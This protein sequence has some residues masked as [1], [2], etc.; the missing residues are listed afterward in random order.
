MLKGFTRWSLLLAVALLPAVAAAQPTMFEEEEEPEHI[1]GPWLTK[2]MQERLM[3]KMADDVSRRYDFDED[4]RFLTR[5]LFRE[6]IPTWLTENR[7]KIQPLVNTYFEAML[8]DEP[9]DPAEVAVWSAEVLPLMEDFT[10]MLD[11]VGDGMREYMTEDQQIIL[12]GELAAFHAAEQL[13]VGR[14]RHWE[15]GGYNAETD[16][17]E[18]EGFR[19]AERARHAETNDAMRTARKEAVGDALGRGPIPPPKQLSDPWAKYVEEFIKRYDLNADQQAQA[20]KLLQRYQEQRDSYLMRRDA[21]IDRVEEMLLKAET[22]EE[23]ATWI[24]KY[25]SLAEPVETKFQVLKERLNKIPTR[26]QRAAAAERENAEK[27]PKPE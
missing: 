8:N 21:D 10:G 14:L 24:A 12:E 11:G 25:E 4:Q 19:E 18:S 7:S 9:P 15:Q 3:N 20:R 1:D 23:K 5:E 16:W 26:A 22:E 27:K 6:R 2:T 17:P 13:L